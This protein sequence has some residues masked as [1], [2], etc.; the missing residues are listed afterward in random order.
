[1]KSKPSGHLVANST[2]GIGV[3]TRAPD[4][5]DL[6]ID[7]SYLQRAGIRAIER[8]NGIAEQGLGVCCHC[9][10]LDVNWW[11]VSNRAACYLKQANLKECQEDCGSALTLLE[12]ENDTKLRGKLLYRRAKALFLQANMPHKRQEDDLQLAAK[13]LMGLLSF[14]PSNKEGLKL[15]DTIR[16]QHAQE[17][18]H[19]SNT[20]MAKS[21]EALR[22]KDDNIQH[23]LKVI[24]GMLSNDTIGASMEFGRLHGVTFML[25]GIIL[26]ETLP[27]KS[28]YLALQ[29]LSCAGSHPPFCRT[30][31]KDGDFQTTLSSIIVKSATVTEEED[32][33]IGSL[34][35]Y[36][37]LI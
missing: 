10:L 24:L 6:G 18:K 13:D 37:R 20:P 14:D 29:C 5:T 3:R 11:C 9:S 35:V 15:L 28:R 23:N 36:L 33:V 27:V 4:F 34:T 16:A 2:G 8:A 26:D 12:K 19:L 30:F 7:H 22:K 32:L 21:L 17:S 31:M 1:M 25:E